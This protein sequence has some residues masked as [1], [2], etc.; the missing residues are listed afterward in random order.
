M[1]ER[2]YVARVSGTGVVL[3]YSSRIGGIG[4]VARLRV[5]LDQVQGWRNRRCGQPETTETENNVAMSLYTHIYTY[6]GLC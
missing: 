2:V 6:K 4:G 3:G 1:M 5:W